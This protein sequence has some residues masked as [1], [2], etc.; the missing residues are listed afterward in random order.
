MPVSQNW[1]P[2]TFSASQLV[3]TII[4]QHVTAEISGL[5]PS[6][7]SWDVV[8]EVV[9]DGVTN[10]MTALQCVQ[11]KGVWPTVTSD[12]SGKPLITDL[13]FL[14]AAFS[15]AFQAAGPNTRLSIND[16]NTGKSS[17]T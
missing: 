17:V 14:H 4:P 11:N 12:G 6:V 5:G 3:N 15:A 10:G 7:T 9:G 13:S 8:N 2:G 1:L 16:F